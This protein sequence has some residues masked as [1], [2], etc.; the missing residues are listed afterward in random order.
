MLPLRA[1]VYLGVMAIK[2]YYTFSKVP[3]YW[4]LTV[5][6]FSVISRPLVGVG[7]YTSADMQSVYSAAQAGRASVYLQ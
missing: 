5:R 7:S 6:L 2:G 4:N 1:R 3:H